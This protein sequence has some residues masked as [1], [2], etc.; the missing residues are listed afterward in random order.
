MTWKAY[1]SVVGAECDEGCVIPAS[2]RV[3]MLSGT[4]KQSA[5][6]ALAVH[7]VKKL[8]LCQV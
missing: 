1:M 2:I 7:F 5:M 4:S 3:W 8:S 6:L